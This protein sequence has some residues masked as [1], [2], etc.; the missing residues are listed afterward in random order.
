MLKKIDARNRSSIGVHSHL[1]NE[2]ASNDK[3]IKTEVV[4]IGAGP[5]GSTAAK[6]LADNGVRVLLIDKSSFPRDKPCGGGL[7][8]K[9]LQRFPYT[10]DLIESYSSSG[11]FY[12]SSLSCKS[13]LHNDKPILAMILRKKFDEGLMKVAMKSGTCFLSGKTVVDIRKKKDKMIVILDDGGEIESQVVIGCDGVGSVVAKKTGLH[14]QRSNVDR[15]ICIFDEYPMSKKTICQFFTEKKLVHIFVNLYGLKGYGWIFPKENCVNIGIGVYQLEGE[16]NQ[17]NG[18]LREVYENYIALLKENAII[19]KDI[20]SKKLRGG[21]LPVWPLE[22][23]YGVG[24]LLCGDAAGLINPVSG[25]GIYFAMVS[26][27]IAAKVTIKA[28]K[29]GD[30]S[31]QFLSIYQK[32]WKQDFGRYLKYQAH[33][34]KYWGRKTDRFIRRFNHDKKLSDLC[35]SI[36]IGQVSIGQVRWK[37]LR[38]Y[39]FVSIRDYFVDLCYKINVGLYPWKKMEKI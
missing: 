7:T 23:T 25:E 36:L 18:N 6:V 22:K 35:L 14:S 4:V 5:A 32:R 27:E 34:V 28:L 11:C 15:G 12:A 17:D 21:I 2:K 16:T 30:T 13:E 10:R 26:G 19:P 29:K 9:V 31:E 1:V 20:K 8:L 24:V 38:R 3:R 39:L 37:L 33:A